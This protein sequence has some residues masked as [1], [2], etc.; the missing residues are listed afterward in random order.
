M[1]AGMASTNDL[2][3]STVICLKNQNNSFT[4][5]QTIS[6]AANTSALTASYSVTGANTTPLLNLSGTWNTSGVATGL[7][8]NITNTA[9]GTGSRLFEFQTSSVPTLSL[10]PAKQLWFWNQ[11][12]DDANYERG[13]MRWNANVLEIGTEAGGT[14]TARATKIT[15][16]SYFE[17]NVPSG[18]YHNFNINNAN[19][20][21]IGGTGNISYSN[22]IV[23]SGANL[24][25]AGSVT[26]ASATATGTTGDIQWDANFIYVCTATSTWKRAALA[27]W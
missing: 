25:I 18:Q 4:I 14:G 6:P 22:L 26:P 23:N 27:T 9:S 10:T 15:S 17:S 5:G 21:G 20:F 3:D 8:L 11:R 13:F 19:R 2:T 24:R 16:A 12:T 1:L 7:K